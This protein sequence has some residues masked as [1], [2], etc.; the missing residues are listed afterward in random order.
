METRKYCDRKC[1]FL[2]RPLDKFA[3]YAIAVGLV[4]RGIDRTRAEIERFLCDDA[5]CDSFC[6]RG[7]HLQTAIATRTKTTTAISCS[8]PCLNPSGLGRTSMGP[9]RLFENCRPFFAL[10]P[11]RPAPIHRESSS[12]LLAVAS[13]NYYFC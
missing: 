5:P 1:H 3:P 9:T 6:R 13:S 4:P 10:S 8:P 7:S 11:V 12:P 2:G